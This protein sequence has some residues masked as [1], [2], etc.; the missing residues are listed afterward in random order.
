MQ[1]GI[2]N[3]GKKRLS[4][5]YSPHDDV[6]VA[7]PKAV[8]ED[9]EL[10]AHSVYFIKRNKSITIYSIPRI[11]IHDINRTKHLKPARILDYK[12]YTKKQRQELIKRFSV[13]AEIIKTA[14]KETLDVILRDIEVF[15]DG[16]IPKSYHDSW[17]KTVK[18]LVPHTKKRIFGEIEIEDTG[19][20]DHTPGCLNDLNADPYLK[21]CPI[22][23]VNGFYDPWEGCIHCYAKGAHKDSPVKRIRSVNKKTT[24]N[25]IN[26]HKRKRKLE[27]KR[28]KYL[29]LAK[30]SDAG[31]IDVREQLTTIVEAC[32]E[33][34]I[35]VM[36]PNKMLEYDRSLIKIFRNTA[37]LYSTDNDILRSGAVAN[38][39]TNEFEFEQAIKYHEDKANVAIYQM[40]DATNFDNPIFKETL[41][42]SLELYEDIG[43]KV[44]LLAIRPPGKDIL[45]LIT[46]LPLD[47]V[48]LK[49]HLRMFD[50][51]ITPGGYEKGTSN[52][53]FARK[54]DKRFLDLIKKP[55]ITFCHHNAKKTWC[56]G[57]LQR[58]PR[59]MKTKETD[60]IKRERKEK[61]KGTGKGWLF[62]E[63]EK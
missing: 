28:T 59:E 3:I 45:E 25:Q 14:P 35:K 50:K 47:E 9:A 23:Q 31:H 7:F 1:A 24:V 44:Q 13:R 42:K 55:G 5:L 29:R 20:Q 27:G 26:D 21:S 8:R 10:V 18:K 51:S 41:L 57:C 60:P 58:K 38:G 61:E 52:Q 43:M 12:P 40:I 62:P 32:L 22:L 4:L 36:F 19:K 33:T 6:Y 16:T 56:G 2:H 63:P 17:V 11:A 37:I 54:I 46:G 49:D 30:I 53:Y 15:A 34:D 48:L 39:F